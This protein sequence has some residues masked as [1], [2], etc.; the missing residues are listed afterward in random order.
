MGI[1]DKAKDLAQE[2]PDKVDAAVDKAGDMVN[3][4]TDNQHAE[5]VDR[6]QDA[7]KDKLG[8]N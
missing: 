7:L 4:K 1:F 3:E 8:N 2:H 5:H 6:A